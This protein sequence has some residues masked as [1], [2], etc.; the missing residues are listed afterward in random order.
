M[1]KVVFLCD[2]T[3]NKECAK[4]YCFL[5]GGE[6]EHTSNYKCSIHYNSPISK[7]LFF[8]KCP[9]SNTECVFIEHFNGF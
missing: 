1:A 2:P 4:T 9:I 5:N 8:K 6:C 3:L 7:H